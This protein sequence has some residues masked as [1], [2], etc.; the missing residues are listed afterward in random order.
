M[1]FF[2]QTREYCALS[3]SP[4]FGSLTGI[5][6][7]LHHVRSRCA[8]SISNS[9]LTVMRGAYSLQTQTS[10]AVSLPLAS[11]SIFEDD[12]ILLRVAFG[13]EWD[14]PLQ[15]GPLLQKAEAVP[16]EPKILMYDFTA[17]YVYSFLSSPSA[18]PT[19]GAHFITHC[20]I[21]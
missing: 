2:F 3:T 12:R 6:E 4:T 7:S 19:W 11:L 14:L 18:T 5:E 20:I 10:T 9:S 8:Q 17:L 15:Q 1:F 13:N 21:T 16:M